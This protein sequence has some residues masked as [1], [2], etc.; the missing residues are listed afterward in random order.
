MRAERDPVV[1]QG[2]L[3]QAVLSLA[4]LV[5]VLAVVVWLRWPE[6]EPLPLFEMDVKGE[7][8]E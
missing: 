2:L 3:Q 5:L 1:P 4:L 8:D 6:P 7:R